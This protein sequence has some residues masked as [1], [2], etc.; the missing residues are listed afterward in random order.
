MGL[1]RKNAK[2]ERT[3]RRRE[4]EL[5]LLNKMPLTRHKYL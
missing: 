2:E 3:K 1:R 5:L 4:R